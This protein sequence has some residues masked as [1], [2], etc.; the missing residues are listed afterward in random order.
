MSSRCSKR[1]R[2]NAWLTAWCLG[3]VCL[4]RAEAQAPVRVCIDEASP[5]SAMDQR[6]AEAA[7]TSQGMALRTVGF[8]GIGRGGD[9]F[10]LQ[11]FQQMAQSNCELIL[12]FPLDRTNPRLP[13]DLNA[14]S[15]Y[16]STGFV[17]V[18]RARARP[19]GLS[20]LPQGTEVGIAQLDT[21]A[22]L[23]YSAHPNIVMHVYAT[24]AD[25]LQDLLSGH[26]GAALGWQPTVE[27][28]SA[29]QG[30][31][32][33]L[34]VQ[35]I[36]ERHMRWDLIALHGASS[37]ARDAATAFERGVQALQ[38]SARLAALVRPLDTPEAAPRATPGIARERR[39]EAGP[40]LIPISDTEAR[41]GDAAR[42]RIP[43]L[44]TAEQANK[45]ALAYY[46]NCASCHGT[47]LDGQAGG[48]SGPALKG[49]EFADPSYDF[50]LSDIFNFVAKLMPAGTPG[51]L[52]PEQ[53]V[54]I[55]SFIL[56]QNG[57]PA[58]EQEL[59]YEQASKSK[60][61]IRYYGN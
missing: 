17:L 47:V 18:Q 23:L 13:A 19:L 54:E 58:G 1:T 9:G 26:I 3:A 48:A 11:R 2:R 50:R 60:V 38:D 33:R 44:Y 52:S 32:A 37:E 8:V 14:T 57:Y 45:G 6:V 56:Q 39:W 20:D 61:P 55:M 51:S 41:H 53:D 15:P 40:R 21:W 12:G 16:A 28:D 4:H 31:A 27:S 25:M 22:G 42:R 30:G 10:P 59:T 49:A 46:M 43:A 34:R 5:T 29:H 35:R 24:D 36:D 7:L